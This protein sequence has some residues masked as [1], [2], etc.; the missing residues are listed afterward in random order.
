MQ[1]WVVHQFYL[2]YGSRVC[3]DFTS[4]CLICLNFAFLELHTLFIE[5]PTHHATN[6]PDCSI[7][8]NSKCRRLSFMCIFI[9]FECTKNENISLIYIKRKRNVSIPIRFRRNICRIMASVFRCA[10]YVIHLLPFW[11]FK[12]QRRAH[13]SFDSIFERL[14]TVYS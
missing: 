13:A 9:A 3:I 2:Y 5:L 7:S 1:I 12:M 14:F 8:G 4:L 6:F 10:M 11:M